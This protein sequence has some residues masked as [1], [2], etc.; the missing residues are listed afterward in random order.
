MFDWLIESFGLKRAIAALLTVITEIARNDPNMAPYVS[1][2]E[3]IAG[4][5]GV[6][7]VTHSVASEE[8]VKSAALTLGALMSGVIAAAHI[9]PQLTP[10]MPIFYKLSA[11]L[12]AYGLGTVVA[13]TLK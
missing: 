8:T 1:V 9:F 6:A 3:Q 2:V 4:W 7:G 11:L 12:S 13:K 10:L 5:L